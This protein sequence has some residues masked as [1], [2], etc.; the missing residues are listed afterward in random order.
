MSFFTQLLYDF[1]AI[2][3][4]SNQIK[5]SKILFFDLGDLKSSNADSLLKLLSICSVPTFKT[6]AES[7]SVALATTSFSSKIFCF[8]LSLVFSLH[9]PSWLWFHIF[10][11]YQPC[12]VGLNLYFRLWSLSG[13]SLLFGS[14]QVLIYFGFFFIFFVFPS[15]YFLHR[16][17][18]FFPLLLTVIPIFYL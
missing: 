7:S 11:V 15:S 14:L 2:R 4:S 12:L 16:L 1:R 10:S 18:Y 13:R 8:S 5:S 17:F 9:Y 6:S 3:L